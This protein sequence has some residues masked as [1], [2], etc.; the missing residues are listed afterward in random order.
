VGA[1]THKGFLSLLRWRVDPTRDEARNVALLLVVPEVQL[2]LVRSAP[3][4]SISPRLHDQGIVDDLLVGLE[5]RLSQAANPTADILFELHEQFQR[6]LVVTAP[7]PV[8]L[9]DIEADVAALYRA[10][11]AQRSGGSRGNTKGVVRDRLTKQLRAR[12]FPAKLG[13]YIDDFLFDIVIQ[14]GH[15]Q[16]TVLE[17]LSFAGERKDWTPVEFD[18]GHFLYGCRHVNAEARAVVVPPADDERAIAS[19]ER[20]RRWLEQEAVPAVPADEILAEP[21]QALELEEHATA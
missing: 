11:L 8:A 2:G 3:L 5:Q 6:S 4:N 1:V 14:N 18:A 15:P 19:F 9:A 21:Q 7:K 10:Y 12:G 17:V 20:V 16:P 13:Q